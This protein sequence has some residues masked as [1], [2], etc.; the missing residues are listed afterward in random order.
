MRDLLATNDPVVLSFAQA[1]LGELG[2]DVLVADQY[3]AGVEGSLGII[4]RRLLVHVDDARRA[5][6]ALVDAGL[7][8]HLLDAAT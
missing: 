4:P 6:A 5:R 1:V 8:E 3:F 7:G 2:I